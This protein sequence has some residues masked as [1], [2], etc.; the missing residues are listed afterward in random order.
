VANVLQTGNAA[1][2]APG[3][4]ILK[5]D[6]LAAVD[7]RNAIEVTVDDVC[8]LISEAENT[9]SLELTFVRY[10]GPLSS[11]DSHVDRQIGTSN[12]DVNNE[13]VIVTS[14]EE[15]VFD[16]MHKMLPIARTDEKNTKKN[17]TKKKNSQVKESKKIFQWFGRG[18]KM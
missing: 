5:G 16:T 15:H 10:G 14:S 12:P 6:Q 4:A 2:L 1:K 3:D 13:E 9:Q 8:A 11:R 18:R 17:E 7:G